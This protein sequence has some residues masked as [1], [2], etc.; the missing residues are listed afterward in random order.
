MLTGLPYMAL[1]RFD[2]CRHQVA[3]R[4]LRR[5]V[6]RLQQADRLANVVERLR[7]TTVDT[8]CACDRPVQA[9]PVVRIGGRDGMVETFPDRGGRAVVIAGVGE[10]VAEQRG[11]A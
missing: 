6:G 1:T 9:D 10:R 3:A 5:V 8:R 4:K 11:E 2:A 7:K